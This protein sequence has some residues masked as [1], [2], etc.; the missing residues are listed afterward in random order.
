MRVGGHYV[1]HV[2]RSMGPVVFFVFF[3]GGLLLFFGAGVGADVMGGGRWGGG[4]AAAGR[5]RD[6]S[7]S[8]VF[9]LRNLNGVMG[10]F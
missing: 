5:K 4:V 1:F 8:R 10:Y 7:I 9:F 2:C 6:I 3:G